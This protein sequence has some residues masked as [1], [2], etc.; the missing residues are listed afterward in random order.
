MKK[1]EVY[2]YLISLL[3]IS[4]LYWLAY[5]V[6]I[7]ALIFVLTLYSIIVIITFLVCNYKRWCEND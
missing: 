7:Y 5:I 2:F 4:N 1:E 3:L 6:K